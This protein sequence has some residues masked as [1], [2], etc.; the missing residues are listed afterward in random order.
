MCVGGNRAQQLLT[1]GR[2]VT[3]SQLAEIGLVITLLDSGA[4]HRD[5]IANQSPDMLGWVNWAEPDPPEAA[6][7]ACGQNK[8]MTYQLNVTAS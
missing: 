5:D 8:G 1:L 4:Q 7:V 2:G 3:E 6:R